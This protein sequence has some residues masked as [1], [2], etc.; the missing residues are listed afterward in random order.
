MFGCEVG[1]KAL[2]V[3]AAAAVFALSCT[4]GEA[5]SDTKSRARLA[6]LTC[7]PVRDSGLPPGMLRIDYQSG[8]DAAKDWALLV[9][10]TKSDT[11]IVGLHGHG[12]H[13]DSI[14][15]RPDLR[16]KWVPEFARRGM[17]VLTPNL[18]DNAWMS[19][20]AARDLH[21]LLGYLRA[22]YRVK[23]FVFVGG[24]MGGTSNLIY[25][26][27]YP[28]DVDGCVAMC[29]ATD[30]T[31]YHAWCARYSGGT[32]A[33]I[34][35]AIET[36]YG[37][38]PASL[39]ELYQSHSALVNCSKLTM[40]VYI[41]HGSSDDLIPVSQPRAL[42]EKMK[43]VASFKYVEIPGGGHD[44]PLVPNFDEGFE[45]VMSRLPGD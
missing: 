2:A 7:V 45:W 40:P 6:I 27:L 29:P 26:M 28:G 42:A 15:V 41:A 38:T 43:G 19:P 23:R 5:A 9:P 37:G 18:R 30:L 12:G 22:R 35:K 31:S 11:W 32:Q 14:Y 16:G 3:L 39:P 8:V 20:A 36:A 34:G 13:A 44:S 24:S 21:E 33:A 4:G 17:G 1:C 10:P 25:A